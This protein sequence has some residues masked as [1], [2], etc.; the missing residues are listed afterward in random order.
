MRLGL[1]GALLVGSL[2]ALTLTACS[3]SEPDATQSQAGEETQEISLKLF[4]RLKYFNGVEVAN[5]PPM[6]GVSMES[7]NLKV[8]V[9]SGIINI[10]N[11]DKSTLVTSPFTNEDGILGVAYSENGSGAFFSLYTSNST[12]S[13]SLNEGGIAGYSCEE[14]RTVSAAD[15]TKNVTIIP[16]YKAP[17][18]IEFKANKKNKFFNPDT[19]PE[20][21]AVNLSGNISLKEIVVNRGNCSILYAF[22]FPSGETMPLE[23]EYGDKITLRAECDPSEVTFVADQGSATINW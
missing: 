17:Q 9:Q 11:F 18:I 3:V 23:L 14:D 21:E 8:M 22:K 4:C 20:I 19:Y 1:Y 10:A 15:F 16:E 5:I 2:F 6:S 12:A 7:M 13:I